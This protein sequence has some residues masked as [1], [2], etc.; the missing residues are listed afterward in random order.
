MTKIIVIRALIV[1]IMSCLFL[2]S[3]T[4]FAFVCEGGQI[5]IGDSTVKVLDKC[6]EPHSKNVI[7]QRR[8]AG[9]FDA[10]ASGGGWSASESQQLIEQWTYIDIPYHHGRYVIMTFK[11]GKLVDIKEEVK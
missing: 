10:G 4:A 11:G 2:S 9:G 1:L 8:N 5:N 3:N 6:G 7:G